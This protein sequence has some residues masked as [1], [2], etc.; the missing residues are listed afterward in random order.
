MKRRCLIAEDCMEELER[1]TEEMTTSSS[2]RGFNGYVA[3]RREF[4]KND[5][6]NERKM[7]N[8]VQKMY[9]D[10]HYSSTGWSKWTM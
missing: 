6:Q 4:D 2:A 8:V 9:V 3:I 1:L 10:C 7:V 5:M